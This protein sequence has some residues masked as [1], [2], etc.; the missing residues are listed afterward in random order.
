MD[1]I[2]ILGW[3]VGILSIVMIVAIL[4][5]GIHVF[6]S[7]IYLPYKKKLVKLDFETA[8]FILRT[9]INTEL[10]AYENDIFLN[11]GSITNSNFDNYYKDITSKII[12]NVSPALI[13]QLSLYISED[14]VY[15]IIARAVKKYLTDKITGTV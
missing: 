3:F 15:I 9:I 12:A 10:D 11:K 1:P 2:A 4:L 14:M 6:F 5:F 7:L 8:L 13:Q